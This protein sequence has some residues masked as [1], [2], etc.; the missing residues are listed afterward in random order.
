MA[1]EPGIIQG[2]PVVVAEMKSLHVKV[3]RAPIP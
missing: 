1:G 2:T 3:K